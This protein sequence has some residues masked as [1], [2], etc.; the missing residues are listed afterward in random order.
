MAHNRPSGFTLIELMIVIGIAA[1]LAIIGFPAYNSYKLKLLNNQAVA[2]IG[3]IEVAIERYRTDHIN[4][5]PN[6]LTELPNPVPKDPPGGRITS[7][8]KLKA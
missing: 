6:A 8:R 3:K 7:T 4:A 5:L 2:D 1:L